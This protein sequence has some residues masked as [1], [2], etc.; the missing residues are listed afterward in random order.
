MTSSSVQSLHRSE[1]GNIL[2]YVLLGIVL[3]GLLTVALRQGGDPGKDLDGEKMTIAASQMQ[4]Y[5]GQIGGAIST[6]MQGGVSE[7]DLRFAH[8]KNIAG[9]GTITTTPGNQVFHPQ[10]GNVEFKLPPAGVNDGSKWEVIGNLALPQVGSARPELIAILPKVTKQFCS[11]INSQLGITIASTMSCNFLPATAF[12]GTY[13]VS[14]LT[15]ASTVFSKAPLLQGCGECSSGD[16]FYF[17][18]LM[19]R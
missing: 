11:T 12:T 19:S 2:L 10:G 5:A 7:A 16:R 3:I 18:V 4:S 1:G 15:Y 14:P 9:Y 6:M 17:Y 13:A 8:P